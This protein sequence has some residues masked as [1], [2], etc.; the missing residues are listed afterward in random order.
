MIG[1]R[2]SAATLKIANKHTDFVCKEIFNRI[3]FYIEIFTILNW[4]KRKKCSR[5]IFRVIVF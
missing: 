3:D 1:I 4:L 2:E 5:T